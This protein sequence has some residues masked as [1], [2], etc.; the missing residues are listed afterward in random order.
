MP[1]RPDMHEF[2]ATH[3]VFTPQ[4]L[5]LFLG[6]GQPLSSRAINN[7][8]YYHT[9]RGRIVAA[10]GGVYAAVP[11][12]MDASNYP[13][14]PYLVAA[15]SAPGAILCLHTALELHGV[16]YS[17]F[18]TTTCYSAEHQRL[19]VWRGITYRTLIHPAPLRRVEAVNAGTTTM[20][21]SGLK[22]TVT[23]LERTLVDALTTPAAAGGVEEVWRS[24]GA[25]KYLDFHAVVDY[26]ERLGIATTAARVGFFLEQ[27]QVA[28]GVP[29]DILERLEAM[30]PQEPHYFLRSERRGGVLLHRWHLMVPNA[31]VSRAWEEMASAERPP[32]EASPDDTDTDWEEGP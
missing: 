27:H 17:L 8:L 11:P 24:L 25:V 2:L 22:L 5:S 13:V 3:P 6:K 12:G 7:R 28:L 30:R 21:R 4:D 26:V 18:N 15:Y 14:D 1:D 16:A 29:D 23:T 9:R 10:W 19:R 32:A 20:D 31:L